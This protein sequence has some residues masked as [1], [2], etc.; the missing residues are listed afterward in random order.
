MSCRPGQVCPAM[1]GLFWQ[2]EQTATLPQKVTSLVSVFG[3]PSTYQLFGPWGY[4]WLE[5]N[6]IDQHPNKHTLASFDQP[7][8]ECG[9]VLILGVGNVPKLKQGETT[10]PF[11]K[12]LET[13]PQSDPLA[14]V[15]WEPQPSA[16]VASPW[17][18][19]CWRP[20]EKECP[21]KA[22]SL[23]CPSRTA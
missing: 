13:G 4:H 6:C 1:E 19:V 16:Q 8:L 11:N 10:T 20:Q 22:A 17:T 21:T 7:E 12:Q 14:P 9:T 23:R 3:A 5:S 2:G 15:P 18:P